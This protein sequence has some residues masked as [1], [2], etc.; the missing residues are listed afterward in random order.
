MDNWYVLTGNTAVSSE[1]KAYLKSLGY[2]IAGDGIRETS[3]YIRYNKLEDARSIFSGNI[4]D[5]HR[6]NG[7]KRIYISN[8]FDGTVPHYQEPERLLEI[9]GKVFSE[10]TIKAALKQYVE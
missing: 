3:W 10:S 9:D 7:H 6:Y 8:I 4:A 2:K 5:T 1:I